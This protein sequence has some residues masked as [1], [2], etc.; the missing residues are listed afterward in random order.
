MNRPLVSVVLAYAAGLLLAQFYSAPPTALLALSGLMLVVIL[1]FRKLSPYLLWPLLALA[2]WSNLAMHTAVI[3]PDDLRTQLASEPALVTVHGELAETPRL[4]VIVR[5]EQE[6]WRS[7]VRVRVHK[8]RHAD[9]FLPATGEI[10]VTTP[11]RLAANY[12]AG[13]SVEISGVISRPPPPLAEGL[14][15]PANHLRTRGIYYQLQ[16]E[17]TNDWKLL[18]PVR[19]EPPLTDRFL[20]WSQNTL[21]LGLP[22]EDEPL[23]LLWAMTLGWRTAFT[24]DIGEPFLRAGT[25][26]DNRFPKKVGNPSFTVC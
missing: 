18:A 17:S 11:G 4:K 8:M 25:I 2:G 6:T 9:I 13:Q 3:A 23:R 15:D 12:F 22:A 10:V 21:A 14:F 20:N 7:I 16:T 24:G 1:I 26:K 5:D 19:P